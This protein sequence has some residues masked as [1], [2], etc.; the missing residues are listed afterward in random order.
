MNHSKSLILL[1]FLAL[2]GMSSCRKAKPTGYDK[3]AS[4][5][6]TE[7]TE[8]LRQNLFPYEEQGVLLGQQY[9]TI[10]GIGWMGDSA[11]ADLHEVSN[12][13]P[14]VVGGELCGIERGAKTNAD[15][16]PFD[17][18]RSGLVAYLQKQGLVV[19]TWTAP[20]PGAHPTETDSR[21]GKQLPQWDT[22]RGPP[23]SQRCKR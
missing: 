3:L 22:P 21:G 23:G 11:R 6:L 9:A 14:A 10:E 12:D 8:N 7:R 1:L 19:L 18:L 17:L 15:S 13:W 20:N 16:I 4:S 5:G 2:L